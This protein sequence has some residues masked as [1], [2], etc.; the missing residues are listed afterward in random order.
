LRRVAHVI[1][2]ISVIVNNF[3][4]LTSCHL[5]L[6]IVIHLRIVINIIVLVINFV[7]NRWLRLLIILL[8][9]IFL[10]LVNIKLILNIFNLLCRNPWIELIV[11]F[12]L[13][14][15][16]LFLKLLLWLSTW[17]VWLLM[18]LHQEFLITLQ[19]EL[20]TLFFFLCFS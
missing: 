2:G 6:S 9:L 1:N 12:S 5:L 11:C 8:L 10:L 4:L 15:L 13:H 18:L 19:Y 7:N 16:H 14:S 17:M 3:I 20:S